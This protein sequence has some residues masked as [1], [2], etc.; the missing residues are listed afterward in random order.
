I[1]PLF[2]LSHRLVFQGRPDG[3][4]EITGY[5]PF[6]LIL[7][8]YFVLRKSAT[9]SLLTP[10]DMGN[11]WQRVF[12]TPYLIMLNL[13]LIFFPYN[14]HSFIVHYPNGYLSWQAIAGFSCLGLFGFLLWRVRKDKIVSFAL[15]SFLIVLFPVINIVPTWA[16]TL[17]S[18]RWLYFPMAFLSLALP[19]YVRK[20]AK[21]NRSLTLTFLGVL[22]IYLG[23]YSY[24]LNK[25]LWHDEDSFFVQEIMHF[26]NNYYAH[27]YAVK[28]LDRK[29]YAEAERYFQIA[30]RQ[31]P[32]QAKGFINYSALLIETGRPYDAFLCLDKAKALKMNFIEKGRW[33]NNMGMAYFKLKNYDQALKSFL[34]AVEFTQNDPQIWANLGGAYGAIGDY[35]NSVSVLKKGL[36]MVPDS[37][38]LKKNLA[39]TYVLMEDYE[40]AIATLEKIPAHELEKNRAIRELL[41]QS[42]NNLLKR[43]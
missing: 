2:F 12:F 15:F 11:L 22:L 9:D 34:E 1:L 38:H 29:K 6:V 5:L 30:I 3:F 8:L 10:S 39:V 21:I 33:H 19:L 31:Y 16:V 36:E 25:E 27:G 18:M 20:A 7:I 41:R 14:L 13:R 17:I 4:R 26:N 37:L 24:V 32:D 43:H 40:K 35:T 42:R 28:L 23:G